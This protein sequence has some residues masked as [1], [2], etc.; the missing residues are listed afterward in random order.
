LGALASNVTLTL[1]GGD[2]STV[3]FYLLV[4]NVPSITAKA[5]DASGGVGWLNVPPGAVQVTA[6]PAGLG[7]PSSRGTFFVRAGTTTAAV[8]GPTP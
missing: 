8:L 5:T 2:Q 1:S 6:S 3:Q 4:G 7:Q